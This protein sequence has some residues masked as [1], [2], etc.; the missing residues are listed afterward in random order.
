MVHCCCGSCFWMIAV[1]LTFIISFL[2]LAL[3]WLSLGGTERGTSHWFLDLYYTKCDQKIPGSYFFL[4]KITVF[5]CSHMPSPSKTLVTSNS[6]PNFRA[7]VEKIYRS[8]VFWTRQTWREIVT[9]SWWCHQVF[10]SVPIWVLEREKKFGVSEL[11]SR[12]GVVQQSCRFG[13][14]IPAYKA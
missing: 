14:Q 13:P 11:G 10:P 6:K 1:F 5:T 12:E 3:Y 8:P 4:S 9:E 2:S 7:I